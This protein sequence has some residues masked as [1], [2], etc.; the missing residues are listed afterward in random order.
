MPENMTVEQRRDFV[1]AGG[2]TAKIVS[3][4]ADGRPHAVPVWFVVDGDDIICTIKESSVKARNMARD[5]RVT[6]LVDDETPPY[7]FVS[8]DGT[9]EIS[10]DLED[11]RRWAGA[12]GRRYL[13][14][15]EA[16]NGFVAYMTSPGSMVAR[17]RPTHIVAMDKVAG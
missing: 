4:R 7:A 1:A 14:D 6:V 5:P 12:I 15:E 16:V 3:L 9:A 11:L 10:A 13:D 2:R 17:I 8:I